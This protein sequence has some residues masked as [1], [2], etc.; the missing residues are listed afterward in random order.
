MPVLR[1]CSSCSHRSALRPSYSHRRAS[2]RAL[3]P[4]SG[5]SNRISF[6]SPR[7]FVSS[8]HG[9]ETINVPGGLSVTARC[10][11]PR[12][13][14]RVGRRRPVLTKYLFSFSRIASVGP[15]DWPQRK[16]AGAGAIRSVMR[17]RPAG[18]INHAERKETPA[19]SAALLRAWH[20]QANSSVLLLPRAAGPAPALGALQTHYYLATRTHVGTNVRVPAWAWLPN[21]LDTCLWRA[22]HGSRKGVIAQL[23]WPKQDS[24]RRSS[25][26]H[27]SFE[28]SHFGTAPP[29]ERCVD[30]LLANSDPT[31]PQAYPAQPTCVLALFVSSFELGSVRSVI[32]A[33]VRRAS[34]RR[35]S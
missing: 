35:W 26:S 32:C 9:C 23:V 33:D 3:T 31:R 14:A 22:R 18:W 5:P 20:R 6:G 30:G 8:A 10:P 1:D 24:P 15:L 7:C 34:S 4:K 12:G 27:R 2:C 28:T 21:S 17:S 25:G 11:A 29:S 19:R 16:W 13:R